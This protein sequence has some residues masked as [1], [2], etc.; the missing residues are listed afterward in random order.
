MAL[1]RVRKRGIRAD[2]VN[3]HVS[4]TNIV[5]S[6]TEGT[7]VAVG[8]TAQRGSTT[9]QWRFN[10]TTGY[11]EGVGASGAIASLEPDPTITGVDDASVD[12][13]AGG[14]QTFVVTGTSFSSGGTIS[15]VGNDGST[16]N[17][18]TTTHNSATQQT[19]VV[20]KSSFINAKE[21]YDI[22][23]TSASNKTGILENAINVDNS[24]SWSTAAGN[25]AN[26]L[27]ATAISGVTLSATDPDS[28]TVTYAETTSALTGAGFTLNSTTGAITGTAGSVGSDTTTSFTVR[29]TAGSE[30]TDRTFNIVTKNF[31]TSQLLYDGTNTHPTGN[32]PAD[33]NNSVNTNVTLTKGA[34]GVNSG[35]SQTFRQMLA[36]STILTARSDTY[37]HY[38]SDDS[39]ATLSSTI[40]SISGNNS[41]HT[42]A[43]EHFGVYNG[44]AYANS[45]IWFTMDLGQEPTFKLTRMEG[46]AVWGTGNATFYVYGDNGTPNLPDSNR[47]S[48]NGTNMNEIIAKGLSGQGNWDTGY[49]TSNIGFYRYLTFR[50]KATSGSYDYGWNT[51]KWYGD[52]Y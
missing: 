24:P 32:N 21:P 42:G 11:F 22:K 12:S 52:Y 28:D 40:W 9:G 23:F 34:S 20:A 13:A 19:A 38:N 30:T 37:S 46:Y 8:N 1:T 49:Q 4:F 10:E 18:T 25:V 41:G 51:T 43:Y 15:F 29:A 44:G 39:N 6:G 50:I 2:A 47:G 26:V 36:G 3:E 17:A 5:D 45:D 31:N 35:G 33:G 16:F 14:N 48:F 7:K 27:E